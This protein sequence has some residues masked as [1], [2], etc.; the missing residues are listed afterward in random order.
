MAPL[1]DNLAQQRTGRHDKHADTGE[2]EEKL[3]ETHVAGDQ[4]ENEEPEAHE[5]AETRGQSHHLATGTE[6]RADG[7]LAAERGPQTEAHEAHERS[8]KSC[9][10]DWERDGVAAECRDGEEPEQRGAGG[11]EAHGGHGGEPGE[12]RGAKGAEKCEARG[13]PGLHWRKA[14]HQHVDKQGREKKHCGTGGE[15]AAVVVGKLG[16]LQGHL[17]RELADVGLLVGVE[18]H[19]VHPLDI[20]GVVLGQEYKVTDVETLVPL[21]GLRHAQRVHRG[22]DDVEPVVGPPP[23][24]DVEPVRVEQHCTVVP[25]H[26]PERH[27]VR[28]EEPRVAVLRDVVRRDCEVHGL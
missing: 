9:R 14:G 1:V 3:R 22:H 10:H 15:V 24:E 25:V 28:E 20:G 27:V 19:R 4:L 7:E 18:T 6:W 23:V 13:V 2:E 26:K 5:E 12:A 17:W 11:K 21:V 8:G 16:H